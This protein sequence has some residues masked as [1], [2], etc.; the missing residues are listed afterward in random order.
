MFDERLTEKQWVALHKLI[1]PAMWHTISPILTKQEASELIS[2]NIKRIEMERFEARRR[3]HV[4]WR[5]PSKEEW[6]AIEAKARAELARDQAERERS[7]AMLSTLPS[8]IALSAPSAGHQA[9]SHPS[10]LPIE[11]AAPIRLAPRGPAIDAPLFPGRTRRSA[12]IEIPAEPVTEKQ[13]EALLALQPDF[14]VG[15]SIVTMSRKEAANRLS[16]SLLPLFERGRPGQKPTKRQKKFL[17]G[18]GKWE[19]GMS[20]DN[21]SFTICSMYY[22]ELR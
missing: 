6:E 14:F 1:H 22:R 11:Q 8:A 5:P 10:A 20:R 3:N 18:C 2:A 13:R 12:F 15:R 16:Y 17:Q 4:P 7:K 19:D 21:A 9:A